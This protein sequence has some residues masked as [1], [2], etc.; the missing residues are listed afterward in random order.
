M[1][2][3]TCVVIDETGCEFAASVEAVDKAEAYDL[4]REYYPEAR[5]FEQIES[6]QDRI[7]RER[8]LYERIEAEMNGDFYYPEE[9]EW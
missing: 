7:D 8:A 4:F 9:E 6:P 1:T 5:R 3:Y 2:E